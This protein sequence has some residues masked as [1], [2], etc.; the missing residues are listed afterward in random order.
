M[1]ESAHRHRLAA[2]GDDRMRRDARARTGRT[3]YAA[4]EGERDLSEGPR[5]EVLGIVVARLLPRYPAVRD[6]V[7]IQR[8]DE[9]YFSSHIANRTEFR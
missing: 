3:L 9:R 7:I 8:Q 1:I 4:V 5:N 6:A 2:N